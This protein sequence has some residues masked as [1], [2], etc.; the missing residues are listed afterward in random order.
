M[1]DEQRKHGR[2]PLV[3]EVRW[4]S[5]ASKYAA[6]TTDISEGGCFID[7]TGQ[8]AVGETV[9]L[10]LG[11]PGGEWIEVQGL[12]MYEL[13]RM[14]FGVHFTKISDTDR[15]RLETL[16]KTEQCDPDR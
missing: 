5:T 16:L 13:P 7:T 12:I 4:A 14:G 10:K 2:V 8:V 3:V 15:K 1:T 11:L 9:D 6:R